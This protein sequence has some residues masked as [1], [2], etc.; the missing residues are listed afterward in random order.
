MPYDEN[1][2]LQ[3]I[4]VGKSMKGVSVIDSGGKDD[5]IQFDFL[6]HFDMIY[7]MEFI[8]IFLEEVVE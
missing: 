7:N 6:W 4:A 5:F 1:S 8:H 2:F 3:G